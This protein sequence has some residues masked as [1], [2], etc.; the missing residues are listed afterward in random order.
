[1]AKLMISLTRWTARVAALLV[2][3]TYVMFVLGEFFPHPHSG[4][5]TRFREW[6]GIALLTLTI[7]AM[8]VA[9]KWELAGALVSLAALAAFVVLVRMRNYEVVAVVAIPG[10][11]FAADW[12]LRR[13]FLAAT[14]GPENV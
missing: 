10:L 12:V 6:A 3:G 5:P 9:W 8:L 13:L 2:A 7:I 11:L 1:M 14:H 4:P